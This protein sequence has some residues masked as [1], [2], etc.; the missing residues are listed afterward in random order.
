V[1]AAKVAEMLRDHL[2]KLP[3]EFNGVT[4]NVTASFGVSGWDGQ[5]PQNASLDALIA[6]CD[7]CVYE[8]KSQGRNRV[9]TRPME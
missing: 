2:A 7:A 1:N 8:S 5:V 9:T 3:I 4:V 6:H